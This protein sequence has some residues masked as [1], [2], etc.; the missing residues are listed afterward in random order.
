[1][2]HSWKEDWSNALRCPWESEVLHTWFLE[3]LLDLKFV[4]NKLLFH[5]FVNVAVFWPISQ[6]LGYL[7]WGEGWNWLVGVLSLWIDW[8]VM[9]IERLFL[10][11]IEV[12]VRQLGAG[13]F[14]HFS[15]LLGCH[16]GTGLWR[17][18]NILP[19][20]LTRLLRHLWGFILM[21]LDWGGGKTPLD[22][23]LEIVNRFLNAVLFASRTCFLHKV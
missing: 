13:V 14:W 17:E 16:I 19:R 12:M 3:S 7:Y 20:P 11:S 1:M 8:F 6:F 4:W 9:I 10:N 21:R 2:I 18:L 5:S 23:S 15:L 22:K